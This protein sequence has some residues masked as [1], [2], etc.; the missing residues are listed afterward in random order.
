MRVPYYY[1]MI[2]CKVKCIYSAHSLT[3]KFVNTAK[4]ALL[5]NK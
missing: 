4:I 5:C 2:L 3:K 1:T